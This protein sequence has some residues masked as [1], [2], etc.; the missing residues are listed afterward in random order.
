[1]EINEALE[2]YYLYLVAEKGLSKN[3]LANYKEDLELFLSHFN[4]IKDT[5]DLDDSLL[6]EFAIYQGE[7][8]L[9]SASISRRLSSLKNFLLFLA[10]ENIEQIN[11]GKVS[12]PKK[13][14]K[15]P[16]V[17]TVEEVNALFNAVDTSKKEGSRDL[18]MLVTMYSSGLRVSELLAL[19]IE[20]IS[21]SKRIILVRSGKGNKQRSVPIN[22]DA[23]DIVSSYINKDR[24]QFPN[25]NKS[26][27]V[28]LNKFGNPMSR[29]YFFVLVKEYASKANI[30]KNIHPHTLRHSFATSLLE[31]G[32]NIV[33]LKAMLGHSHLET[34]QIYTKV[35]TKKAFSDY[36]S[37]FDK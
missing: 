34:T 2:K 15:L 35:S 23:L 17:L 36:S 13:P 6:E 24:K 20:D 1:M 28:F 26:P 16:E 3:T 21:F 27:F 4:D 31:N 22:M 8:G 9:S 37:T 5:S 11:I 30:D 7:K 14:K 18:A 12:L 19:K 32:V 25:H 29:N 33:A 10:K